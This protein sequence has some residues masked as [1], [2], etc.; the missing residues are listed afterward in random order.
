M[1]EFDGIQERQEGK[2]QM[3]AGMTI[4]FIGL[5]VFGLCYMY[6]Y[7]PQTTGWTQADQYKQKM[8]ALKAAV[9]TP[10]AKEAESGM[11]EAELAQEGSEIYKAE[12][13]M[14]HGENLKGSI[15]PALTGPKFIYGA[16]LADHIRVIGSGTPKG[17][18]AFENQLGA[19]KVRAVANYIY[20]RH[21]K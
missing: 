7:S 13:V 3:P 4:L 20:S 9:V 8:D 18:P 6:F 11:P 17:M 5:I 21:N 1:S 2:S 19:E 16:T 14:C 15:G 10:E 12:C